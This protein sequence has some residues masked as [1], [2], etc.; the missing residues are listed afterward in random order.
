MRAN[1]AMALRSV[2]LP[3][4]ANSFWWTTPDEAHHQIR[5]EVARWPKVIK[6]P[7]IHLGAGPWW[8]PG[9]QGPGLQRLSATE[10]KS[11][12]TANATFT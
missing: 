9:S 3:A 5:E 8:A 11:T 6:D 10:G 12:G 4:G 2:P 1:S 7:G